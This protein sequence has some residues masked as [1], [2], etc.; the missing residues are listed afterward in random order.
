MCLCVRYQ[1]FLQLKQDILTSRLTCSNETNV[2]LAALALQC[3]CMR[4]PGKWCSGFVSS[5]AG[6]GKGSI[7]NSWKDVLHVYHVLH[8]CFYMYSCSKICQ[9]WF[10]GTSPQD[11]L[12]KN[13][14]IIYQISSNLSPSDSV[15]LGWSDL[16]S[17]ALLQ[18][19]A[20]N[21]RQ[22]RHFCRC[23]L[24]TDWKFHPHV[25]LEV[26]VSSCQGTIF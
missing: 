24:L 14:R 15:K 4:C 20:S 21:S 12:G 26:L 9:V 2:E 3:K 8:A 19:I 17:Q 11:E 25:F 10:A 23:D 13:L 22:S 6:D 1:L 7:Q 5:K 18:V 16:V